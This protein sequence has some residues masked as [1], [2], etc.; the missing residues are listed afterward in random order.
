LSTNERGFLKAQAKARAETITM[1]LIVDDNAKMRGTIKMV[2]GKA[3]RDAIECDSGADA[4]KLY[5]EHHPEWVLMDIRMKEMDGI[6]ATR[7]ITTENPDARIII[8]TNYD[9]DDFRK[10]AAEAG[11][12]AYVTKDDLSM[13]ENI[14]TTLTDS[15]NH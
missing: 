4:I 5:G 1:I 10:D 9:D 8:V 13:L 15:E 3:A 14:M 12:F 6:T 11:A 7:R 2:I